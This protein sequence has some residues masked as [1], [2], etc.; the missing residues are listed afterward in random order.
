MTHTEQDNELREK[1]ADLFDELCEP[2]NKFWHRDSGLYWASKV[3]QLI[4]KHTNNAGQTPK[5][6]RIAQVNRGGAQVGA[7]V[8]SVCGGYE[9]TRH[10]ESPVERDSLNSRSTGNLIKVTQNQLDRL[11]LKL[12]E[13]LAEAY[14]AGAG[15]RVN[16]AG[17]TAN[18]L[19]GF[20][21]GLFK[22]EEK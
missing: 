11:E 18:Y 4:E 10:T 1:I 14:R 3:M 12:K 21:V 19:T 6:I 22:L 2:I 17:D 9:E 16:T 13:Q 15:G 5:N 7:Q 20:V 8:G